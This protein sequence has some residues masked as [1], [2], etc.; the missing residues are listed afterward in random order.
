MADIGVRLRRARKRAKLTQVEL[1]GIAGCDPASISRLERGVSK[2]PGA[3]LIDSIAK[4]L[5]IPSSS[6]LND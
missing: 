6:L 4:S 2:N 1:A 3:A 5:K